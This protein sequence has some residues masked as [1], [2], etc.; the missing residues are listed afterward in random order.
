MNGPKELFILVYISFNLTTGFVIFLIRGLY[1]NVG[2][3]PVGESIVVVFLD[4]IR[5]SMSRRK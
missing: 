4:Q 1:L 5:R 2:P 3:C